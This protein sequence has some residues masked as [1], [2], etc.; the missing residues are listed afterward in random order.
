MG[1]WQEKADQ[2][3][4]QQLQQQQIQKQRDDLL[5]QQLRLDAQTKLQEG[6]KI[7]QD[8]LGRMS[9]LLN[10]VNSTTNFYGGFGEIEKGPTYITLKGDKLKAVETHEPIKR[11]RLRRIE[12]F[13]GGHYHDSGINVGQITGGE[14]IKVLRIVDEE[15]GYK[16]L[17][18][19]LDIDQPVGGISISIVVDQNKSATIGITDDSLSGKQLDEIY[20]Q[21]SFPATILGGVYHL[22]RNPNY[23]GGI[24]L[25]THANT[26]NDPQG[27]LAKIIEKVILG[28][29]VN[30]IPTGETL[31]QNRA[32]IAQEQAEINRRIGQKVYYNR[33]H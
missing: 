21:L 11:K 8:F 7:A 28:C 5:Q 24:S 22:L 18:S 15:V 14:Y 3:I 20:G 1:N 25:I 6:E 23:G 32:R 10:D 17:G 9:H 33:R 2:F 12:K 13:Y 19:K 26:L 27:D 16:I 4:Q 31:P 29:I 30:K